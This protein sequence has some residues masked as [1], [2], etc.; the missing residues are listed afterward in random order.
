MRI[1]IRLESS[2]FE[3]SLQSR[4]RRGLIDCRRPDTYHRDGSEAYLCSGRCDCGRRFHWSVITSAIWVA[5]KKGE[6]WGGTE[7]NSASGS[8]G[9]IYF[10][11]P[12]RGW[13]YVSFVNHGGWPTLKTGS[14]KSALNYGGKTNAVSPVYRGCRRKRLVR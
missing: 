13:N 7:E 2:V 10:P 9:L 4:Y 1:I 6:P 5:V 3:T 12:P 8:A 11:G 14:F